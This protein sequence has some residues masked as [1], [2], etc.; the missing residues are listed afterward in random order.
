MSNIFIAY[1]FILPILTLY[2]DVKVFLSGRY[3]FWDYYLIFACSYLSILSIINALIH[4]QSKMAVLKY[5]EDV[6]KVL[7]DYFE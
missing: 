4:Q 1:Y 3:E 2:W 5:Y 7:H 6:M